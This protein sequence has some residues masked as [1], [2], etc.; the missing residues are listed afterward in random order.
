MNTFENIPDYIQI[1]DVDKIKDYIEKYKPYEKNDSGDSFV[2]IFPFKKLNS[3]N[4]FD[5]NLMS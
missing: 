1:T 5:N 4:R 2:T 3:C